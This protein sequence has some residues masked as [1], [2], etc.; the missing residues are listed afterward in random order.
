MD[1]GRSSDSESVHIDTA[2]VH[3]GS[4]STPPNRSSSPPLY[5]ASSYEFGDLD[6]IEKTYEN[7]LYS[8]VYGRYGGPNGAQFAAAIAELEG[9]EYAVAAA[10]GMA[11]ID[12]AWGPI[13]GPGSRIVASTELYGG[14]YDLLEKD[15]RQRGVEVEFAPQGDL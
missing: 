5:A 11:A 7:S 9:A 12:A 8:A 6:A 4:F 1:N 2:A 3:A 15:Y 10:S 14:A 13:C